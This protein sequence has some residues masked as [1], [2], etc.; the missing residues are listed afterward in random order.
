MGIQSE[1]SQYL[2]DC[3]VLEQIFAGC[4]EMRDPT[5]RPIFVRIGRKIA[6]LHISKFRPR[7]DAGQFIDWRPRDCNVV[8]D[9]MCNMAMDARKDENWIDPQAMDEALLSGSC[10]Q[11]FT[12][13]GYRLANGDAA[14]WALYAVQG[15]GSQRTWHMIAWSA[16]WLQDCLRSFLCETIALENCLDFLTRHLKI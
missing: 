11:M 7:E 16:R 2:T 6:H 1:A 4:T 5:M 13:G 9:H 8:V 15:T 3:K 14:G 10:F 12:D